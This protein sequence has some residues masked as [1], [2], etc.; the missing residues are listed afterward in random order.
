[1][2][3]RIFESVTKRIKL[4]D[5]NGAFK[6]SLE[7]SNIDDIQSKNNKSVNSEWKEVQLKISETGVM[8]VT[9]ISNLEINKSTKTD[10]VS[11]KN[12]ENDPIQNVNKI[13]NIPEEKEQSKSTG[14]KG[15]KSHQDKKNEKNQCEKSMKVQNNVKNEEKLVK[16]E[17]SNENKSF[18]K[19]NIKSENKSSTGSN[20]SKLLSKSDKCHTQMK[21]QQAVNKETQEQSNKQLDDKKNFSKINISDTKTEINAK[22]NSKSNEAK[23]FGAGAKINALSAKLQFQPKN[24]QINSNTSTK[25]NLTDKAKTGTFLNST[26]EVKSSKA[27]NQESKHFDSLTESNPENRSNSPIPNK[28]STTTHQQILATNSSDSNLKQKC[29]NS[30]IKVL[31]ADQQLRALPGMPHIGKDIICST[32][33]GS[34]P[35]TTSARF[36]IQAPSMTIYS[37]SPSSKH[38]TYSSGNP[39]CSLS[40]SKQTMAISNTKNSLEVT[41]INSLPSVTP[42]PDAIP[43]SLLKGGRKDSTSKGTTLNEICAKIGSASAG[44][45]SKINDICA[46]IGESSKEKNRLEAQR[47]KSEMPELLK[48]QDNCMETSTATAKHIPNIPNVPIYTPSNTHHG[49]LINEIKDKRPIN[50]SM[51]SAQVAMLS[52]QNQKIPPK[53]HSQAIGYKTLRDPPKSWNPSLSKKDYVATK[54]QAKELQNQLQYSIDSDGSQKQIASKPAKIFKIRNMPRYLGNQC[55]T[56]HSNFFFFIIV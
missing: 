25:K 33:A 41:S 32:T 4:S 48:I 45:G 34:L 37:I 46:K 47:N 2:S 14:S 19:N 21:G 51:S 40:I 55:F 31:T 6:Q 24:N 12:E 35:G 16:A 38:S 1:M 29:D 8:S 43:I 36:S 39:S 22:P 3:Y 27:S 18:K 23:A 15:K 56:F 13:S 44:S 42:C 20:E 52:S 10:D 26:S 9:D 54:N 7:D 49:I 11:I 28:E 17:S 30:K 5:D 50:S 53:K